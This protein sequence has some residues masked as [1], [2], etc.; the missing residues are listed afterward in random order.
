M[1]RLPFQRAALVGFTVVMTRFRLP[2]L[3]FLGP[4]RPLQGVGDAMMNE[5]RRGGI[6]KVVVGN[7]DNNNNTATPHV[8]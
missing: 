3:G 7:L 8:V 1:T 6:V 5:R 2:D 4:G